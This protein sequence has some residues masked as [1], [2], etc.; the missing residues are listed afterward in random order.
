MSFKLFLLFNEEIIFFK[1]YL[2]VF[3][4]ND[5]SN[6]IFFSLNFLPSLQNISYKNFISFCLLFS[7]FSGINSRIFLISMLFFFINLFIIFIK[8]SLF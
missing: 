2:F 6:F 7:S 4:Q 1:A 3:S 8:S 5:G